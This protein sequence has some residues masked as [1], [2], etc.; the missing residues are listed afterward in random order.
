MSLRE[1]VRNAWMVVFWVKG[2]KR[3]DRG[4]L[5]AAFTAQVLRMHL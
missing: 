1:R 2:G 4:L 3:S 5:K